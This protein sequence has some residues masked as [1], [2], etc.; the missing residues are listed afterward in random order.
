MSDSSPAG[1]PTVNDLPSFPIRT[2]I[3]GKKVRLS[4]V[5]RGDSILR[6]SPDGNQ[7][8]F[9]RRQGAT[10]NVWTEPVDAGAARQLTFDKESASYPCWSPDGKFIAVEMKRGGDTEVAVLPSAG[11]SPVMLTHD[12]GQ[13]FS[14]DWSPDGDKI[15]FAGLRNGAW[16]IYW[17]SRTTRIEKQLT[18]YTGSSSYVRYPAWSPHGDQIVYEHGETTGNIWLTRVK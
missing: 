11:D 18:N 13:S 3:S 16:N 12:S 1:F 9:N 15:L 14:F 17:V 10:I 7:I 8:A 5:G 4:E 2:A 6:L